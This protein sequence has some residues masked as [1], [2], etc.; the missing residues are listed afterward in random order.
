ML[1]KVQN[2][3]VIEIFRPVDGFA[4]EDCFHPQVLSACTAVSDEVQ[5][6]WV[7]Q[8]DGSFA[9]PVV[10]TPPETPPTTPL[11]TTA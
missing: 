5:V 6:G 11:E 7:Q 1:A 2:N 10:E 8:E 9:A 4:I 3:V